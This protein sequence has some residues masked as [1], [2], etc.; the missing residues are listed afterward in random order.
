[1]KTLRAALLISS[2][3]SLAALGCTAG[4]DDSAPGDVGPDSADETSED[5]T[6]DP[7]SGI[8]C[9]FGDH[10]VTMARMRDL[11]VGKEKVLTAK[12]KISAIQSQQILDGFNRNNEEEP[13]TDV[14]E[15]I[16][17]TDDGEIAVR[18]VEDTLHDRKFRLYVTHAGDNVIGFIYYAGST[19]L[20]AEIGDGSIECVDDNAGFSAFDDLPFFY[21]N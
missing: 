7:G 20:A 14:K 18:E 11:T 3:A 12:S 15:A 9:L 6:F 4:S 17:Q 13:I 10:L 2:L 21:T 19:R 5:G 1:M 8:G 16:E